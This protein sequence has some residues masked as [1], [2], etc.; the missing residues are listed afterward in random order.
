VL[1]GLSAA[2]FTACGPDEKP[3]PPCKGPSINLVLSAEKNAPLPPDTHINVRYGGN[4]EG[5]PYVLGQEHKGPAVFCS[6]D[7]TEGGAPAAADIETTGGLAGASIAP[8]S[9]DVWALSCGLY[10]QGPARLDAK[11]EGYEPIEDYAL[12]F[13]D[14]QRCEVKIPVVLKRA[15][16]AGTED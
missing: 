12:S 7:H 14:E 2:P 11:A 15:M 5:E 10:T 9:G 4:R 16:D 3:Q 6:E 13:V 8:E 1:V